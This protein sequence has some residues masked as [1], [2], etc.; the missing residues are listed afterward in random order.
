CTTTTLLLPHLFIVYRIIIEH[1]ISPNPRASKE[2][3]YRAEK[4][5]E[6]FDLKHKSLCISRR[7]AYQR[8]TGD[9]NPV[10]SDYNFRFM[11][12]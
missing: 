9:S 11:F 8:Y 4:T 6:I 12:E 7:H 3:Q 1:T 10:L 5:I 2:E